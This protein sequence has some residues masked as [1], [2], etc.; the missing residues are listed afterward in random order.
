MP[1]S[2]RSTPPEAARIRSRRLTGDV[3]TMVV[4][5]PG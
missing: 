1:D 2:T 3:A 4:D 5:A